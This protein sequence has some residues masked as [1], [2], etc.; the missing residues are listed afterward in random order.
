MRGNLLDTNTILLA[1]AYPETLPEAAR[2]A[3]LKGPDSLS[4]MSYWQVALKCALGKM[5]VG[6]P[7]EW[8]ADALEQMAATALPLSPRHIAAVAKLPPHHDDP[9]GRMLIAQAQ[10]EGLKIVTEDVMMERYGKT[11]NREQGVGIRD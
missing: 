1:M 10:V 3:I 9:F 2:K 8:W 11:G 5:K 4:A 7:G 6:N